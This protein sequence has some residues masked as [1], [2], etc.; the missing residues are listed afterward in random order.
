MTIS[1][2]EKT[3]PLTTQQ[4]HAMITILEGR[5]FPRSTPSTLEPYVGYV[6]LARLSDSELES[7]LDA[8]QRKVFQELTQH[9]AQ[10]TNKFAW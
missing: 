2:L 10:W 4:R 1:D 3:L 6:M 9:Y 8:P 5:K 7:F